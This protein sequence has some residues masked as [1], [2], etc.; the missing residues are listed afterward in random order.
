[1]GTSSGSQLATRCVYVNRWTPS[2][3]D[4]TIEGSRRCHAVWTLKT[5]L[6][7]GVAEFYSIS[8]GSGDFQVA[9]YLRQLHPRPTRKSQYSNQQPTNQPGKVGAK[10]SMGKYKFILGHVLHLTWLE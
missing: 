4:T 2:S 9:T 10:M 5:W 6:G 8:R 3:P 1:M 7:V